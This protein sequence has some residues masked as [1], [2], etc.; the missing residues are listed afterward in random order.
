VA[1]HAKCSEECRRIMRG[2]RKCFRARHERVIVEFKHSTKEE[3][4]QVTNLRP[5]ILD[6][7]VQVKMVQG[8]TGS[9]WR[10]YRG[11][12]GCVG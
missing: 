10:H 7:E 8:V 3:C 6:S 4:D 11:K 12:K 2:T 9:D 5:W 1:G